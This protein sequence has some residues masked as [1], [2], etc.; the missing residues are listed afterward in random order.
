MDYNVITAAKMTDFV[1]KVNEAIQD[2]W[3]PLEGGFQTQN[4]PGDAVRF[5]QAMVKVQPWSLKE[6]AGRIQGAVAAPRAEPIMIEAAPRKAPTKSRAEGASKGK[7]VSK[8]A[9]DALKKTSSKAKR[10][11]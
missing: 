10:K 9:S 8:K 6:I 11:R 7:S 5:M 1:E 3:L 2:G 4:V